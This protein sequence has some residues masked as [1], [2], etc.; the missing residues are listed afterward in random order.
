MT[1][2]H[3]RIRVLAA[4]A[5]AGTALAQPE[6]ARPR[7]EGSDDG[8]ASVTPAPAPTDNTG[9]ARGDS[10]LYPAVADWQFNLRRQ[11]GGMKIADMN[12]DGHNDLVLGVYH[13]N[14][15]PE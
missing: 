1:A 14:S 13:S 10:V 12:G 15:F 11:V 4:A 9:W 8:H 7:V 6:P 5:L 2:R 3:T